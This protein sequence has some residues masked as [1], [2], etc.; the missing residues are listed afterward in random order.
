LVIS[1]QEHNDIVEIHDYIKNDNSLDVA[2][3]VAN[4]IYNTIENIAHNPKIGGSVKK[5][6]GIETDHLYFV[7]LPYPYLVFY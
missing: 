2:N 5:R 3:K 6:F 1:Q 4:R 7:V